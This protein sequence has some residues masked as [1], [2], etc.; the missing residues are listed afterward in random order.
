M[1][2]EPDPTD[3]PDDKPDNGPDHKAEAEK[4]KA[5][6][7][8]HEKQAKEN[9]AELEKLKED[10]NSSKSDMD[11]LKES[12][13]ELNKRAETAERE[14]LVAKV[15]QAKKLPAAI[16]N[17]LT[18]NSQEELEEDADK[19]IE[20]LG[21]DTSDKEN[22][23]DKS[24]QDDEPEDKPLG[25]RPKEKLRPGASND[26]EPEGFDGGKIAEKLLSESSW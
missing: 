10:Q 5:L 8:K 6:A 14:A 3:T 22:P 20:A 17:R 24:D 2:D 4:W 18:G 26:D 19:L 7:R 1:A 13:A 25:G 9:L 12:I 23:D 11:K 15:A 16:A 21:I